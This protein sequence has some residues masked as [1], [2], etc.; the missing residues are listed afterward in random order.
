VREREGEGERWAAGLL[1]R[2][3]RMGRRVGNGPRGKKERG[4]GGPRLER[5]ER[6]R[7]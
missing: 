3:R 5:R 7:V 6:K 1:G 2:K 4:E